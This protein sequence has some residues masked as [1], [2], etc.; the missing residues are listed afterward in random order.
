MLKPG[1]PRYHSS[2]TLKVGPEMGEVLTP[3]QFMAKGGL[4]TCA[5]VPSSVPEFILRIDILG[6]WHIAN[7]RLKDTGRNHTSH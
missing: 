1:D 7:E 4:Q 5:I 6:N 3:G 2:S